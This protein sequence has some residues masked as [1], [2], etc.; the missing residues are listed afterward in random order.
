MANTFKNLTSRQIISIA[1]K[2]DLNP[3][4]R[5]VLENAQGADEI[6]GKKCERF[7]GDTK[8]FWG[9][10]SAGFYQADLLLDG[11]LAEETRVMRCDGLAARKFE[12]NAYGY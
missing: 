10:N 6:H 11:Y 1:R 2:Y 9:C 12:R 7:D 5:I 8:R 4:D 3:S